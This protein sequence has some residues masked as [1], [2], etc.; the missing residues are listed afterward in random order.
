VKN[1]LYI[2]TILDYMFQMG[3]T[4]FLEEILLFY[5]SDDASKR[6]DNVR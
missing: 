3:T 2:Y 5:I 6:I 1:F 4:L